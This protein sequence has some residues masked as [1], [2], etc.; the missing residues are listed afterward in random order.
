MLLSIVLF[1]VRS[2]SCGSVPPDIPVFK[3]C[4]VAGKP[5]SIRENS[6]IL[7]FSFDLSFTEDCQGSN[8]GREVGGKP[9]ES[10]S[11]D[12]LSF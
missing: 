9:P 4:S 7:V 6:E 10:R 11:P 2:G 8:A 5:V 12:T 1:W 3:G